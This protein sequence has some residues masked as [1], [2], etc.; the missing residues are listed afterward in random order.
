MR[1]LV[2]ELIERYPILEPGRKDITE[3]FHILLNCFRGQ[4]RTEVET[5]ERK[6]GSAVTNF[7]YGRRI[8]TEIKV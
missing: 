7:R 3:A 1:N 8:Y 5:M 6:R 4:G 2:D